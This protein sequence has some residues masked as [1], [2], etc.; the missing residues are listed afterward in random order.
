MG[1]C[2]CGAYVEFKTVDDIYDHIYKSKEH[3]QY[4]NLRI[5]GNKEGMVE[6]K[7]W[8]FW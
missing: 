4:L 6:K 7:W 8:K 2:E 1:F 5:Y 3:N